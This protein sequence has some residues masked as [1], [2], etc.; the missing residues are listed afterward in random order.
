MKNNKGFAITSI[1]YAMLILFLGLIFLIL[2]NLASRKAM[3]DKEKNEILSRFNGDDDALRKYKNG[4]VVYFD[5][6]TGEQCSNYTETQSNTGTKSGCMKFYAFNDDGKD[7]VNLILD[8][9][10]TAKAAWITK[11]DYIAAGGEDLSNVAACQYG[12]ICSKN[13]YGPLTL[14]TQLKN[15]TKSWVGT[16][17]PSNYTMDQTGQTSNA[18]YT[19]DYSSY[20]A[21]LI[22]AQEI[23]KITG[24]TPWNEKT[25]ASYDYYFFDSK[26]D[27][28]STTCKNGNTTG[29]SYG[30][31]Y[32]RTNT[33]CIDSGCLNNSD[34]TTDGYWTSS[35]FAM[36][37]AGAWYVQFD[38]IIRSG[39][40]IGNDNK[41]I[42]V[43][44]VIEVLK[45]KLSSNNNTENTE[46]CTLV[47]GKAYEIGSKYECELGDN[48]EKTFFVLE[49]NGDNVSLIMNKNID[50]N[51]KG[52][53]SGNTVAWVTKEDYLAAG[54]TSNDYGR[55]GNNKFGPITAE[56]ALK[57][58]TKTWTKL[59]ESQISLPSYD[60][61]YKA[62]G[63]KFSGLSTW[64][65]GNLKVN[66]SI[67]YG[68]WTSTPLA[69]GSYGAWRVSYDGYLG[70]YNDVGY[71]SNN[72]VRPVITVSKSN[73]S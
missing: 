65:Y 24:N 44:P 35:S 61:I 2:G 71:D 43:R 19:I 34:Q 3:F 17:T 15:D 70:G 27:I 60:Q 47:S 37:T 11:E 20:K 9:N 69:S 72:G 59:T 28:A 58:N 7:T 52:T 30:W 42:G 40:I 45:S 63:N 1:I 41:S 31:L 49:T 5:V 64:L 23:A 36:D 12:K 13:K 18:K 16:K 14:L 54:G 67:P 29:C 32:D 33:S 51:G 62:A 8:H 21:R 22:T 25:A 55:I 56:K 38:S 68:Y 10:T 50:S 48:D 6:T 46:L 66:S 73:L 53:T 57:K 26:T 4:E 39:S